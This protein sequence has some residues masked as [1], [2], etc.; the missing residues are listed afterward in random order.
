MRPLSN[1]ERAEILAQ[2]Q[3]ATEE[4]LDAFER[5]LAERHSL[6]SAPLEHFGDIEHRE[7]VRAAALAD[8]EHRIRELHDGLLPHFEDALAAVDAREDSDGEIV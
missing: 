5:L 7:A 4:T 2:N 8:I 1:E 3:G 6:V